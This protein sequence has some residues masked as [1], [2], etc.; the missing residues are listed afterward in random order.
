MGIPLGKTSLYLRNCLDLKQKEMAEALGIS[1]VHYCNIENGKS[2][3]SPELVDRYRELWDVDLHVLGWSMFG[4]V[5]KL[6]RPLQVSAANLAEHWKR[7]LAKKT[8]L[9]RNGAE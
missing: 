2:T 3:P 6:P 5:S 1:V 7:E 9:Q 4:D 8:V